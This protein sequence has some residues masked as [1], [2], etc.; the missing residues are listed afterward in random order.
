LSPAD[1]ESLRRHVPKFTTCP[2]I[3]HGIGA[4]VGSVEV[5]KLADLVLWD[6]AFFAIRPRPVIKGGAIGWAP[7]GDQNAS[8]PTPQPIFGARG[9]RARGRLA[10]RR[11]IT[12][13]AR[14]AG[15]VPRLGRRRGDRAEA[16]RRAAARAALR[17][18]LR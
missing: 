14:R 16:R 12:F 15:H 18:A 6:P 17:V 9:S 1:N 13:V 3:A 10:A 7:M 5:G 8:T 4:G 11:S 2:V